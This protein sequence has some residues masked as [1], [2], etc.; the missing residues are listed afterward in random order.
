MF[1]LKW[2]SIE[3]GKVKQSIDCI[4]N[5]HRGWSLPL[6]G[7][8]SFQ[9]GK[10]FNA[11]DKKLHSFVYENNKSHDRSRRWEN[12]I[13]YGKPFEHSRDRKLNEAFICDD[14]CS[15][16]S[17]LQILFLASECFWS[18]RLEICLSDRRIFRVC[19][20][21]VVLIVSVFIHRAID[22]TRWY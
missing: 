11:T 4:K 7:K 12:I 19:C 3:L 14:S 20:P 18:V 21:A 9:S 6:I 8:L 10:Y 16:Y 5:V 22:F 13:Q 15:I 1:S 17:K 2:K